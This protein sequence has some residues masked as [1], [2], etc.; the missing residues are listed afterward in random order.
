LIEIDGTKLKECRLKIIEAGS[1]ITYNNKTILTYNDI[2]QRYIQQNTKQIISL[3]VNNLQYR[4]LRAGNPIQSITTS[5]QTGS[6]IGILGKE[7][8]GKTTLL[9]LLS[10]QIAPTKGNIEINGYDLRKNRY[11]LKDIIGYVPEEDLLFE[12]LSVFDNLLINARLYYSSLSRHEIRQKIDQLLSVLTLTDIRDKIVGNIMNKKIQPGQRRILNIALE[13]L[14][15][16]QILLVDN[17]LAGLSLSDSIKVIKVL[18]NYTLEGNLV[19]TSVSQVGS[20]MFSYFDDIWILDDG[21]YPVYTGPTHKLT[22]YLYKHLDYV[23][24]YP[25]TVDSATIIDLINHE[26][27]GDDAGMQRAVSPQKWHQLYLASV[28][29]EQPEK[30]RKSIFPTRPIKIPNLE[31]Q[32]LI[33]SFRNF[34]CKFSRINNLVYIMLSGPVV[35]LILAFFLRQPQSGPSNFSMNPNIPAYQYIS[36]IIAMFMGIALSAGEI[37]KERNI[38]LKEQYLEFS[39][40]SYINSKIA[41]LL[42]ITGIQCFLYI[43]VGNALLGIKGMFWSYWIVI[44]SVACF[45]VLTGLLFSASARKLSTIYEILVPIFI[46]LQVLFGGGLIPYHNLN[47]SKSKYIPFIGELMV[48]RWGYEALAV[49]QFSGNLYQKNFLE[50][51]KNINRSHYYAFYLLPELE[52]IIDKCSMMNP[53]H[54]SLSVL[55]HI[56]YNELNAIASKT[57]V[58]PFEFLDE[59]KEAEINREL[60]TETR[61]YLTWLRLHFYERHENFRIQKDELTQQLIDSLGQEG[62]NRLKSDHYNEK[63]EKIVTNSD[64][65]DQIGLIGDRFI[66]FRNGIYQTPESNYGRALM[67]VTSKIFNGQEINTLWFNISIIW[68]FSTLIYLILLTD[69]VNYFR[70]HVFSS[71]A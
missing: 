52:R 26:E 49:R 11:L 51:D 15:E 38:L 16:P 53:G 33:F 10:G 67:F 39:L 37:L 68:M 36:I 2:K 25:E 3:S 29:A 45:G 65:T 47:L 19:I 40:F 23:D 8:T 58:F 44:Y 50:V 9:K 57:D 42:L 48:S 69:A 32:F 22:D 14:R 63:L 62:F 34:K 55:T 43:L 54:D 59:L 1:N 7:G 66:R 30:S 61:D 28:R 12:E 13:L 46:A 60:L 27:P 56:V 6:L 41:F 70:N 35:A 21:G 20:N 31:I 71:G 64:Y 17:A 4:P 5:E 18:H 24:Q